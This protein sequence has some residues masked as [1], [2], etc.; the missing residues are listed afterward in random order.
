MAAPGVRQVID[1]G[2]MQPVQRRVLA[3]VLTVAMLDGMDISVL[4]LAIPVIA[5]DWRLEA[6]RFAISAAAGLIGMGVGTAAGGAC[7]DRFGPARLLS[8]CTVLFGFATAAAALSRNLTTLTLLRFAAG[9]GLGGVIPNCLAMI[10]AFTPLRSRMF[11]LAGVGTTS[12]IGG[13]VI[14]LLAAPLLV[15]IGWRTVFVLS[16]L[17][18]ILLGACVILLAPEP[19]EHLARQGQTAAARLRKLL[20]QLRAPDVPTAVSMTPARPPARLSA[21]FGREHLAATLTLWFAFNT[22]YIAMYLPPSWLPT[23]LTLR[24]LDVAAASVGLAVNNFA[25]LA[26][27]LFAGW[28]VGRHGSRR[29]MVATSGLGAIWAGGVAL[30]LALAPHAAGPALVLFAGAQGFF[31]IGVMTSL[32]A[33]ASNS[34]PA[35]VRAT[36]AGAA[37]AAARVG[38]VLSSFIGAATVSGGGPPA[39]FGVIAASLLL[40]CLSLLAYDRHTPPQARGARTGLAAQRGEHCPEGRQAHG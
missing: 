36:G 1:D 10:S 18:P 8:I 39:F 16:G 13:I 17:L 38:A 31:T 21:L 35:A 40:T 11:W 9:I 15:G 27:G 19:P 23:I 22:C 4:G 20:R 7:G 32:L 26:G 25:G 24:G 30:W 5:R 33:V 37:L 12:Q 2:V 6:A 3:L 14:G 34:Y 28:I 29:P